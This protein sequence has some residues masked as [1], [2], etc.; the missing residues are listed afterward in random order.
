MVSLTLSTPSNICFL[1]CQD[2]ASKTPIDHIT[3]QFV[4]HLWFLYRYSY[5]KAHFA[6]ISFSLIIFND[7]VEF[8]LSL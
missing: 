2:D 1:W 6:H 7:W 4:S 3:L 5:D 8:F